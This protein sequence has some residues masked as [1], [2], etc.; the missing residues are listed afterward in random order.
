M[1]FTEGDFTNIQ[2]RNVECVVAGTFL[3]EGREFGIVQ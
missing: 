2:N 1:L 3:S